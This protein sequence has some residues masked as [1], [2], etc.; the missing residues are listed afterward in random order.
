MSQL[1]PGE[2]HFL[3]SFGDF[4]RVCQKKRKSILKGALIGAAVASLFTLL[5]PLKYETEATF[6]EKAKSDSVNSSSKSAAMLLLG[7]E[8]ENSAIVMLKSHKVLEAAIQKLSLHATLEPYSIIPRFARN[9]GKRLGN[10]LKN[11][12]VEGAY[13]RRSVYPSFEDHQPEV[14]VK[15]VIYAGQ[16]PLYLSIQFTSG[17]EFSVSDSILGK[18]GDGKLGIPFDSPKI[19]FTLLADQSTDF[20]KRRFELTVEPLRKMAEIIADNLKVLSDYKDKSFITLSLSYKSRQGTSDLL[21][22]IMDAYREHLIDEHH[23]LVAS[24]VAYLNQRRQMM[25]Q[26]LAMLMHE[27]AEKMTAHAGNLDLLIATQQNLQKKLLT[28]DLEIKQI[29]KSL[30][31]GSYVQANYILE[32]DPPF[33][34]QTVGEIRRFRQ[35]SHSIE[36]ALN[37]LAKQET[38]QA[39]MMPAQEFQGIDLETAN[40][41]YLSYCRE[42]QE[43][44]T[45]AIQNQSIIDKIRSKDFEMSS[46]AAI[47]TDPVSSE[48]IKK[49]GSL[50]LAIK[51]Q[52]NRTQRELERLNQD[53][54]LQR[55][56]LAGHLQQVIEILK[57]KAELLY[58]KIQAIQGVSRELLQQKIAILENQLLEYAKSRLYTLKQEQALIQQQKQALQFEFDKLPEQWSGEKLLDIYLKTDGSLMQHIGSLIESKNIADHLEISLS[59]P[60]DLAVPPLHPK[61]PHL[62]IYAIL[63]ACLGAIGVTF[64]AFMQS[65][66]QGI[67]A[68]AEN[69]RLAG[70]HVSGAISKNGHLSSDI[71]TLRR[72]AA[73]LCPADQ[74]KGPDGQGKAL[75]LLQNNGPN[76]SNQLATLLS[77]RGQKVLLMDL[78]FTLA[79]KQDKSNG[80]LGYLEGKL[81]ALPIIKGEYDFLPAGGSSAFGAELLESKAFSKALKELL[82]QYD[83]VIAVSPAPIGSAEAEIALQQFDCV[84]LTL[85]N[86]KLHELHAY[87]ELNSK[88]S[89]L[90][91]F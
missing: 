45:N 61:S 10:P 90:F 69:L 52:G 2:E 41:L 47:L 56:F 66:S 86:E 13:L 64:F 23:R 71:E 79:E 80:I 68:T 77:K 16:V 75:L 1:Q 42:L 87:F 29:Q 89:F 83:L 30:D 17:Q 63:G 62:L 12:W 46:L 43:A 38:H 33:V 55:S 31:E 22:A 25:E 70:R 39:S 27:H 53:L 15:D 72:L 74:P 4:K 81:T 67:E 5:K 44:Q 48:I 20:S 91:S 84:A 60:F 14:Y 35:Q 21:N 58:S 19:T 37:E 73:Y 59:A 18:L 8:R 28:I 76:Y 49:S 32:S 11:L 9:L 3:L 51:D 36:L 82:F 85:G 34:H 40:S 7:E 50:A 54:D 26:Q 65:A 78:A 24:Q 6:Y 88:C 57:L